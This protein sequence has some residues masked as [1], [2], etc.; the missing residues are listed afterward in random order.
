MST[1]QRPSEGRHTAMSALVA[2]I[3]VTHDPLLGWTGALRTSACQMLDAGAGAPGCPGERG[4][5]R[6]RERRQ[7]DQGGGGDGKYPPAQEASGR[8]CH[9]LRFWATRGRKRKGRV[10]TCPKGRR[11]S[12]TTVGQF[13]RGGWQAWP[14]HRSRPL[15]WW[16]PGTSSRGPPPPSCWP[17]SPLPWWGA[18]SPPTGRR[19]PSG[20]R[21]APTASSSASAP[22]RLP[23]RLA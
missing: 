20:G 14:W 5:G 7:D 18:S 15:P 8:L 1:Y 11:V 21:S 23:W 6:A 13:S 16:R 10:P 4:R 12:K 17:G 9:G 22:R 2:P 19:I 3:P